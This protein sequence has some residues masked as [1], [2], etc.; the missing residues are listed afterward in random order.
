V[1]GAYKLQRNTDD[2]LYLVNCRIKLL[3]EDGTQYGVYDWT[4]DLQKN[5]RKNLGLKCKNRAQGLG[6]VI[7]SIEGIN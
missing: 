2:E 1:K 6:E 7:I 3:N 4:R 5:L